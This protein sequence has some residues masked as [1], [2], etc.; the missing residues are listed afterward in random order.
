MCGGNAAYLVKFDPDLIHPD[1]L[2]ETVK[3]LEK[4]ASNSNRTIKTRIIEVPV[5]YDDPWTKKT[6]H[7]FRDRHQEPSMTDLEYA[8]KLNGLETVE[9]FINMHH[10][11]PW[12]V[13]QV[14]FVCGVPW[15]YQLVSRR[16]QIK[17]L[18]MC[19]HGLIH[20]GTLWGTVDALLQFMLYAVLGVANVW[21][22]TNA[23]FEPENKYSYFN[24]EMVFSRPGDIF[25]FKPINE[26]EFN[27]IEAAV[28]K[29]T[30][31]PKIKTVEFDLDHFL[32]DINNYNSNL[33][34][35]LYA[36]LKF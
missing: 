33:I 7:V 4:K 16:S 29:D 8:A 34:R 19:G 35:E 3:D 11:S 18:S 31:V 17:F 20:Q 13:S 6:M 28:K 25:K 5:F 9:E 14:G 26:D 22:N 1:S 24:E 27:E 32:K 23:D 12:F 2:L 10:S 36:S 15:L 30:F 21:Y